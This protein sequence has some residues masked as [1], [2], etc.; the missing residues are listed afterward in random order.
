MRSEIE[1]V[2]GRQNLQTRVR[3]TG[4][5]SNERLRQEIL[6]ARALVLASFAE[7]LPS[8]LMEALALRRPV[9]STFIAGIPELVLP[10]KHGWLVP[11]GDVDALADAMQACLDAPVDSLTR[12]GEAGHKRVV[13]RH[14]VEVTAA[15]LSQLFRAAVGQ[16]GP[17]GQPPSAARVRERAG[18]PV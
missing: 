1:A 8:V 17:S 3:L 12:M 16:E 13:E 5:I 15:Q 6:A 10:G 11:P 4:S 2:V 18:A 9:I 7:G 14:N